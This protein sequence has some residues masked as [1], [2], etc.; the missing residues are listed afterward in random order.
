MTATAQWVQKQI[1]N[2]VQLDEQP[3]DSTAPMGAYYLRGVEA[4]KESSK[5]ENMQP[6]L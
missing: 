4:S 6:L 5:I 1:V 3:G 2:A